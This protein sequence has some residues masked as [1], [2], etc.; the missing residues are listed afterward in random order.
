MPSSILHTPQSD[1]ALRRRQPGVMMEAPPPIPVAAG[2]ASVNV[3]PAAIC[4]GGV[5]IIN[6]TGILFPVIFCRRAVRVVGPGK[7]GALKLPPIPAAAFPA[8]GGGFQ[9]RFTQRSIGAS[10]FF[11]LSNKADDSAGRYRVGDCQSPTSTGGMPIEQF[12]LTAG[13]ISRQPPR[14]PTV[15]FDLRP[16]STNRRFEE[17]R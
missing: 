6:C 13:G 7:A 10:L 11:C 9:F 16:Y 17:D 8:S 12:T 5:E 1:H 4:P 15:A 14:A 3:P 2:A